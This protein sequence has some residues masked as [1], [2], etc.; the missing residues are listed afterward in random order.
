MEKLKKIIMSDQTRT[1]MICESGQW[2]RFLL[3]NGLAERR[4]EY[5]NFDYCYIIP[6]SLSIAL[7]VLA[8]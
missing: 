7:I 3:I 2:A 6:S 5:P 8:Q 1:V 4:D